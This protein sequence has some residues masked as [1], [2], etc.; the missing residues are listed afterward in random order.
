VGWKKKGGERGRVY[1]SYTIATK[2]K[3]SVH[4]KPHNIQKTNME[5]Y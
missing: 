5:N 2:V 1:L 3:N 4:I